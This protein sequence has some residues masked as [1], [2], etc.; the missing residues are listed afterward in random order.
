MRDT[1]Q[2]EG[3]ILWS[4]ADEDLDKGGVRLH[5]ARVHGHPG[6]PRNGLYE[7][8]VCAI[9]A[10]DDMH[11]GMNPLT[12][13]RDRRRIIK[14]RF[15]KTKLVNEYVVRLVIPLRKKTTYAYG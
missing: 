3:E 8:H 2:H 11:E 5:K 6:K 15:L 14:G 9:K 12:K 7:C 10:R 13:L 1:T 4:R